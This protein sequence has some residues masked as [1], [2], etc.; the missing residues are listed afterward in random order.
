MTS[1]PPLRPTTIPDSQMS[2]GTASQLAS[3]SLVDQIMPSSPIIR[4]R[5]DEQFSEVAED[6]VSDVAASPGHSFHDSINAND[7][8]II[9]SDGDVIEAS[10]VSSPRRRFERVARPDGLD[11]SVDFVDIDVDDVSAGTPSRFEQIV[12]SLEVGGTSPFVN[13]FV[14]RNAAE[15]ESPTHHVIPD[16]GKFVDDVENSFDQ[17]TQDSELPPPSIEDDIF[18]S[19]AAEESQRLPEHLFESNEQLDREYQVDGRKFVPIKDKNTQ[20]F[21]KNLDGNLTRV[22]FTS[23]GLY[24]RAHDVGKSLFLHGRRSLDTFILN[25]A[26][27]AALPPATGAP[28]APLIA[29]VLELSKDSAISGLWICKVRFLL[30]DVNDQRSFSFRCAR[31]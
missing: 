14:L 29:K 6:D 11:E 10:P 17:G 3:T 18:A 4:Q 15:A 24:R 1:E 19:L 21:S 30:Q 27:G 22:P 8:S 20:L 28:D 16:T 5:L 25:A 31:C 2:F 7:Q 26:S 12:P 23:A 13:R 9:E